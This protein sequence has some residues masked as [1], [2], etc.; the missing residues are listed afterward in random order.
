MNGADWLWPGQA[1]VAAFA[2]FCGGRGRI[3]CASDLAGL[4][5]LSFSGL[6]VER[7]MPLFSGL[8][9]LEGLGAAGV[10]GFSVVDDFS[11]YG[12]GMVFSDEDL[13][14]GSGGRIDCEDLWLAMGGREMLE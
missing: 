6:N 5:F 12:G 11:E 4:P 14:C 1:R 9:D 8:G 3:D 10:G 2:A 13:V 7:I